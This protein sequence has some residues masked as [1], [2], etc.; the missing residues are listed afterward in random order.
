M[1]RTTEEWT[2]EYKK[3][4]ALWIHSGKVKAPHALLA[5]NNHSSGFFNSRLVI[6]DERLLH[7]AG[8]D[9]IERFLIEGGRLDLFDG[10][11]GPETGATLLAKLISEEVS[12]RIGIGRYDASPAKYEQE[13]IKSM[14]FSDEDRGPV[15]GSNVLLCEDVLTT[16]G[17]IDLAVRAVTSLGGTTLP[18]VLVLV[19]RSGL[20]KVNGR[21]VL[22][23]IDRHMPMWSPG[24]CPLCAQGSESIRPKGD[25]WARLNADY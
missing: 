13:G 12:L 17:S 21:R 14:V 3:K 19:N 9:L 6:A 2:A 16:G 8:C 7:E 23:L 18:F 24:D 4:G 25:N 15:S 1:Y 20:E 22:A 10:V 11:V 5:S